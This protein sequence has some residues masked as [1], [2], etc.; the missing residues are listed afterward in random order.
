[1]NAKDKR[2]PPCELWKLL[3]K[4]LRPTVVYPI[5][6]GNKLYGFDRNEAPHEAQVNKGYRLFRPRPVSESK[7]EIIPPDD[8]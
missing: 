7:H 2:L 8:V 3:L 1:M 6:H 5:R 4:G